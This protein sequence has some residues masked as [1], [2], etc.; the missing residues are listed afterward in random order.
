M[1]NPINEEVQQQIKDEVEAICKFFGENAPKNYIK[2]MVQLIKK[3]VKAGP[4]KPKRVPKSVVGPSYSSQIRKRGKILKGYKSRFLKLENNELVYFKAEGDKKVKGQVPINGDYSTRLSEDEKEK[5]ASSN[6]YTFE[7]FNT[8]DPDARVYVVEVDSEETRKEWMRCINATCRILSTMKCF[9]EADPE[10]GMALE[11]AMNMT[12]SQTQKEFGVT[13]DPK[14]P[15]SGNKDAFNKL[16]MSKVN[17]IVKDPIAEAVDQ[18]PDMLKKKVEKIAMTVVEKTVS[19][20]TGP[21]W[22]GFETAVKTAGETVQGPIEGAV[23]TIVEVESKLKEK[24]KDITASALQPALDALQAPIDVVMEKLIEPA[25]EFYKTFIA[26]VKKIEKELSEAASDFDK[27][28]DKLDSVSKK[29]EN[30]IK[31]ITKKAKDFTG[32]IKK[33]LKELKDKLADL[34]DVDAIEDIV[35][36]L[37]NSVDDIL[38]MLDSSVMKHLKEATAKIKALKDQAAD[39]VESKAKE[40]IEELKDNVISPLTVKCASAKSAVTSALASAPEEVKAA[41]A[42]LLDAFLDAPDDA[43]SKFEDSFCKALSKK[44]PVHDSFLEGSKDGYGHLKGQMSGGV[45]KAYQKMTAGMLVPKIKAKVIPPVKEQIQS[46][47]DDIPDAV[48]EFL[49]PVQILEDFVTE[50]LEFAIITLLGPF[51]KQLDDTFARIA[52]QFN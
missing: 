20:I 44:S 9:T 42:I 32:K 21:A 34:A 47:A 18:A 24:M 16:V 31:D 37:E 15:P 1:S 35:S 45:K 26:E 49:D 33:V 4:P 50:Q 46:L 12:V 28:M 38:G 2:L 22:T 52:A 17:A 11:K 48:K 39:A 27:V 10:K 43:I 25:G 6:T 7:I 5:D 41:V 30:I 29:I 23:D 36:G 3:K 14:N 51:Q 8:K 19:S 13:P 40:L